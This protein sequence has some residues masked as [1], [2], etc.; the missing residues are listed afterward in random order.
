MKEIHPESLLRLPLMRHAISDPAC[1]R[2][3]RNIDYTWQYAL[4]HILP[5]GGFNPLTS[6][7]FLPGN[8]HVA[9]FLKD[10]YSSSRQYNVEDR[11]IKEAVFG[12]IH[13][14]LHSWAY[15]T[16]NEL[17]PDLGFGT[18]PISRQNFEDFVFCHLL[19]EAVAVVGLDYWYMATF[20]LNQVVNLG[21][22]TGNLTTTYNEKNTAEYHR[23]I[24]GLVNVQSPAFF[25]EL[26]KFYCAPHFCG[27]D[28][29][30]PELQA[31][32]KTSP[33]TWSWL[34]KEIEYGET[35]RKYTRWWF[36]HLAHETLE[37][38]TSPGRAVAYE[39][40]WQVELV[41]KL[42]DMLWEKVKENAI[43]QIS[44]RFDPKTT[45]ASPVRPQIDFRFTNLNALDAKEIDGLASPADT[46]QFYYLFCQYVSQFEF[47]RCDPEL[48][49]LL[50]GVRNQGDFKLLRRLF[51]DQPRI[52]ST[53]DDNEVR[54]LFLLG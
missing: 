23:M 26:V 8:S 3:A 10:P 2:K 25:E 30:A 19:T 11:L 15:L 44:F 12:I 21:S 7:V 48:L 38:D 6:S 33:Q 53:Q 52:E 29:L 20:D 35:Q 14:Y 39:Q 43:H 50:D 54:D 22:L 36:R 42:G 17:M 1:T 47:E 5:L 51:K 4:K 18:R 46:D 9:R 45:W 28:V 13:D 32:L 40:D 31:Q 16:I 41:R 27:N 49:P 24:P 37:P 34:K